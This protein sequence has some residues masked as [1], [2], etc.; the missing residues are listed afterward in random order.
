MLKYIIVST[1]HCFYYTYE[2]LSLSPEIRENPHLLLSEG[3]YPW[4]YARS[5]GLHSS[6]VRVRQARYRDN[7]SIE[8]Y[9]GKSWEIRD[10]LWSRD[11]AHLRYW[12]KS[13]WAILSHRGEE[14]LWK[15]LYRRHP[16]DISPWFY[17]KNSPRMEKCKGHRTRRKDTKR[18]LKIK[19][20]FGVFILASHHL[21]LACS[22][23]D[24]C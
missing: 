8:R 14:K 24:I 1:L 10:F 22:F 23:L 3:Q 4:L 6:Q 16:F 12:R 15:S 13:S 20:P 9:W 17:M 5:P 19:T 7:L 18:T 11:R 2:P 21:I